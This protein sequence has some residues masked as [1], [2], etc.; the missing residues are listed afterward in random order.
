MKSVKRIL[1]AALLLLGAALLAITSIYLLV[2]DATLVSHLVKR[3][4]ASSDI[5]VLHRRC[6]YHAHLDPDLDCR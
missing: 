5:R 1:A 4:E 2:D 3:L 6:E